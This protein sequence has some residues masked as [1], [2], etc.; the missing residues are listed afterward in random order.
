MSV[1]LTLMVVLTFVQTPLGPTHA[2]VELDTDCNQ[3]DTHAMVFNM[4]NAKTYSFR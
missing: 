1:A 4:Q 2:A 3:M